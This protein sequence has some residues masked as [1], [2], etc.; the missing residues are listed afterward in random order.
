MET[1][2]RRI[3]EKGRVTL[4]QSIR[5]SLQI[6]GGEEVEIGLEEG[7]IVIRPEVSRETVVER[8]AGCINDRTRADGADPTDP[9]EMAA[10]WT[11]DLP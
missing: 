1:E 7:R 8:M 5:E 2:K 4:P 3:D 6:T 11:S 10:D 9:R